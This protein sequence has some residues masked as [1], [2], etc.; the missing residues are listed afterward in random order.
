M[1]TSCYQ[2]MLRRKA[3]AA[4]RRVATSVRLESTRA[5]WSAV[6]EGLVNHEATGVPAGAG[7]GGSEG[8]DLGRMHRLLARL[9]DPHKHFPVV[10]VVGTKGKG[11]TTSLLANILRASG[12]KVGTYTSP[13]V[14][15]ESE[16]ISCGTQLSHIS[17]EQLE[18]IKDAHMPAVVEAQ[19]QEGGALSYFEVMTALAFKHFQQQQV[20]IAVVEAGLGGERDATNVF[21]SS[22]QLMSVIT[23][24]GMDHKAALGDTVAEIAEVKAGIMQPG[25][26]VVLAR[27]PQGEAAAAVAATA[28]KKGCEILNAEPDVTVLSRGMVDPS[29]GQIAELVDIHV[30]GSDMLLEGVPCQLIGSHQHHNIAAAVRASLQLLKQ[31]WDRINVNA[32]REGIAS[33]VLPGRFQVVSAEVGGRRQRLVLDAAH[34]PESAAALCETLQFALPDRPVALVLAML[35]DKD[36]RGVAAALREATPKVVIFTSVNGME[37]SQQRAANTGALSAAW[38]IGGMQ[39]AKRRRARELVQASMEAAVAKA[40][41]EIQSHGGE[42]VVCVTGSF[43]AVA[44][45]MKT[46]T[47]RD[48]Y[49]SPDQRHGQS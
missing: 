34:T 26:P 23:A 25:S 11:S 27:Q 2:L 4:C 7:K 14:L 30:A 42:G 37:G 35:E 6:Q 20:D 48:V 28:L 44:A 18:Q 15:H 21:T 41:A 31:G 19:A 16:R 36:I 8:F 5:G 33:T 47:F 43:T 17:P 12:Y 24:I 10:Q 13:H 40:L 49:Q 3:M 9:D 45:A 29:G 1:L 38:Q 39:A 22:S 32:I 46:S